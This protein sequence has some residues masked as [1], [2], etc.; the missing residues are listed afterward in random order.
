MDRQGD[1]RF[2][3]LGWGFAEAQAP[4]AMDVFEGRTKRIGSHS[5]SERVSDAG[6]EAEPEGVARW[7]ESPRVWPLRGAECTASTTCPS[8]AVHKALRGLLRGVRRRVV[9]V[10]VGRRGMR[11]SRAFRPK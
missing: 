9:V 10:V 8:Q 1:C 5:W 6:G 2:W 3:L 4:V 11:G 7:T